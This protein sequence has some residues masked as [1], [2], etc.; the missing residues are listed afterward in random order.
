MR[1]RAKITAGSATVA[2]IAAFGALAISLNPA[3]GTTATTAPAPPLPAVEP[4]QPASVPEYAAGAALARKLPEIDP[5]AE[6]PDYRR[7]DYGAAWEDIDGNG[8]RQRDDV[9]A[10]D[11]EGITLDQNGCTV[12]SGTLHDPY[13]ATTVAFQHD[14]VAEPGNPGSQGV[15]IDHIVSLAAA[16]R[17]GAWRW[18]PEQ[19][20]AFANDLSHLIAVDGPTNASKSDKGPSE[21]LPPNAAYACLYAL[22]YVEIV[23]EWALSVAPADKDALVRTL[24]ECAA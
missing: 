7:D 8:C 9:L 6:V 2:I 20:V 1:T 14:R 4:S 12:L 23:D 10:R 24:N 3:G 17:G 18:T 19:R 22:D 21:W 16:H 13:T 15:Q 5:R 11:L